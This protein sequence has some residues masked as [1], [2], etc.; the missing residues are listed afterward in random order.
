MIVYITHDHVRLGSIFENAGVRSRYIPFASMP[1][2]IVDNGDNV[3]SIVGH[4]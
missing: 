4:I 3:L 1:G 2:H